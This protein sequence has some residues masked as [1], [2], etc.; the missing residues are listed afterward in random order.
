MSVYQRCAD[1]ES[2]SARYATLP[3]REAEPARRLRF[4]RARDGV[5]LPAPQRQQSPPRHY[6]ALSQ[7]RPPRSDADDHGDRRRCDRRCCLR[8]AQR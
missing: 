8:A 4:L 1:N 7:G 2:L 3:R 6:G 5:G